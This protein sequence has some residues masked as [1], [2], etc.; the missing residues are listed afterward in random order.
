MALLYDQLM[1]FRNA[2]VL[3]CTMRGLCQTPDQVQACNDYFSKRAMELGWMEK[4]DI[5]T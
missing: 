3:T 1:R 4:T 2:F 5:K